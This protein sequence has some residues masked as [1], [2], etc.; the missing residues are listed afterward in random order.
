MAAESME[1]LWNQVLDR[2]RQSGYFAESTFNS[3]IA[4]T[5]LHKID[6][7]TA[8]VICRY[9]ITKDVMENEK[10]LFQETL[11]EVWGSS[12]DIQYLDPREAESLNPQ[13]EFAA[14]TSQLLVP[15]FNPEYTFD[16]FVEGGS[17]AEAYAACLATCNQAKP[18]FNPLM[19]FGNSGLGKTHLLHA[20]GNYL[21]EE[22][23]Q[24][25][26]VYLYSGDLVTLLIEAMKTKSK[27]GSAVEDAKARLLDCDYF[28]IDDIQ[29]LK[30][31]A[32]QEVFFSVYNKLIDQD[33]QIIITSDIHPTDLS[34]LERRL[35]SRFT[36]GLSINIGKPEFE[37]AKA[38][39]KKKLEGREELC[40]ISE[41]VI[42][43]LARQYSNDVRHLE[44]SLNK[45]LFRATVFNPPVIDIAFAKEALHTEE[46]DLEVRELDI[47]GIKKAVTRFYGLTY[48]DLEGKSR[49]KRIATARHLCVYLARDLLHMP[50]AQI[51]SELGN[52]DHT[53]ISASYTK[54]QE[55]YKKDSQ[56]AE[57]VLKIR[58]KL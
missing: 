23:P 26:V 47:K 31:Q 29:N 4:R 57:A 7:P 1:A 58:E 22:A 5:S 13:T 41:E 32:S 14:R 45:L 49:Q 36:Q 12:V 53:T 17:N 39:L 28:L 37:T 55:L 54:A 16:A 30:N 15:K 51:G 35:V 40:A 48:K 50:Y 44:G 20:V 46:Q 38:I 52:R 43:Y 56:F 6:G 27:S 18:I 9:K 3:W 24:K 19:L 34:G 21:K 25:K 11:S 2:I 42:D 10:A 33:S 8:Y